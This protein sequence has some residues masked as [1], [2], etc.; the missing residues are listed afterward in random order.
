MCGIALF[1]RGPKGAAIAGLIVGFPGTLFFLFVGL[2]LILGV[3]GIG[4]G[5]AATVGAVA[6]TAAATSDSSLIPAAPEAEKTEQ[7][8]AVEAEIDLTEEPTDNAELTAPEPEPREPID[9][10]EP[11][12]EDPDSVELAKE[13]ETEPEKTDPEPPEIRVA[14]PVGLRTWHAATGGFS[15][16]AVFVSASEGQVTLRKT[17]GSEITLPMERLSEEDQE[18]IKTSH[19]R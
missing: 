13:E 19:T 3:L 11:I 16:D 14:P 7:T 5:T 12:S 1:S 18:W 8:I 6:G 4:A 9:V 2:G 17:D 10:E 15:V